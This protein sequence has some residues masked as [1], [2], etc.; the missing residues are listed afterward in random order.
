[1]VFKIYAI[2]TNL[3]FRDNRGGK[4]SDENI[5][6]AEKIFRTTADSKRFTLRIFC[7]RCYSL[8]N[9]HD[10]GNLSNEPTAKTEDVKNDGM[11]MAKQNADAVDARRASWFPDFIFGSFGFQGVWRC[12]AAGS[13]IR[14]GSRG[15]QGGLRIRPAY[16]PLK[17]S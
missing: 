15:S 11:P 14:L 7:K 5:H 8:K 3:L 16:P 6:D 10:A 4:H 9:Y 2:I 13:R 17:S 1:M 12:Q